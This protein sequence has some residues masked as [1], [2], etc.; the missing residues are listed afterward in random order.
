MNPR[1]DRIEKEL[2]LDI[3]NEERMKR[4]F[5]A[6]I[7]GSRSYLLNRLHRLEDIYA[8]YKFT[9]KPDEQITLQ[10]LLIKKKGVEKLLY[11]NSV[12]RVLRSFWGRFK[13]EKTAKSIIKSDMETEGRLHET[14]KAMGFSVDGK[15]IH[16][17][18][19]EASDHFQVNSS[20][21][22]NDNDRMDYCLR[23][24]KD[25][26]GHFQ[27][28]KFEAVL[29][30]EK[31]GS[32]RKQTFSVTEGNIT[33]NKAYN[34]LAGRSVH[35]EIIDDKGNIR[36]SW[37]KLD[38]NDKDAEGNHKVK[39]FLPDYGFDLEKSLQALNLK[40][41]RLPESR[42]PLIAALKNGERKEVSISADGN[43]KRIFIEVNAQTRSFNF[44]DKDNNRS[45]K[46]DTASAKS[47]RSVEINKEQEISA[48]RKRGFSIN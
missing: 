33:A 16:K 34:L 43:E 20:F 48:K 32:S 40:E 2:R 28:E 29:T 14:I 24:E 23:F 27:L 30:D 1:I 5:S 21:Y 35:Q 18:L 15:A 41:L 7:L 39:R 38:L 26:N 19:T 11:P 46:Q 44:F 4:L 22:M 45:R 37:I 9:T 42:E 3:E 25:E 8:R 47:I 6:E 10:L 12:S 31:S 17:Q 36:R 13:E